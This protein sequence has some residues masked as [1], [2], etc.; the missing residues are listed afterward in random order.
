LRSFVAVLRTHSYIALLLFAAV[1]LLAGVDRYSLLGSTEP[2]EAG[3]AAAMLQDQQYVVPT[4]NDQAFL[5][6]P[7]LS[8]WLQS[9]S[10]QIGGTTPFAARLPSILAALACAWLLFACVRRTTGDERAAWIAALALLTMAS[11]WTNARIA[12]QDMLLTLGITLALTGF[13]GTR[14]NPPTRWGWPMYTAGIAVATLSKGVVGLAVPGIVIFAFLLFETWWRERRFSLRAWLLPGAFALLGLIPF[15]LWLFALHDRAGPEAVR[16]ILLSNSIDRFA[17]S[18]QRGSHA[19]PFYYYLLKLPETFAPWNLLLGYLLWHWRREL[20]R[21]WR[22]AFGLC[23]LL[24]PYLLLSLSAGKRPSYLLMIY[25]AAALL[26]ALCIARWKNSDQPARA[27][28]AIHALLLAGVTAFV[29]LRCWQLQAPGV[30]LL[31]ALLCAIA[32]PLCWRALRRDNM[33]RALIIMLALTA[34]VYVGYGGAVLP[35]EQRQ[36]SPEEMF[37]QLRRYEEDGHRLFLFSPLERISGAAR[38]YLLHAVPT[39]DEAQALLDALR[40]DPAAIALVGTNNLTDLHGYR[41]LESFQEQKRKYAIIAA[42][43]NAR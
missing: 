9:A 40:A 32:L 3:I 36:D 37:A 30:A 16:E 18:Y 4:L 23:W 42:D 17:G 24:A 8:Y 33:P 41:I 43:P 27:V 38:F 12:G 10:M 14:E 29:A 26:I 5:E 20:A 34:T 35:H 7:P 25:P 22:L 31:L 11:F 21:D 2:R 15:V 6:K 28:A 1:L 19:E 13:Y 39:F